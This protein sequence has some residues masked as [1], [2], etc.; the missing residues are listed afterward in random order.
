MMKSGSGTVARS[1]GSVG[2]PIATL[3]ASASC[4][5]ASVGYRLGGG[6]TSFITQL[7]KCT[8]IAFTVWVCGIG[9]VGSTPVPHP[10]L[11]HA[12]VGNAVVLKPPGPPPCCVLGM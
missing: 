4:L 3:F 8:R 12:G 11:G 6:A 1:P 2:K 5:F 9:L 7:R 10:E